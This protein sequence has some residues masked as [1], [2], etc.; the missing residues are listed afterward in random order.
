MGLEGCCFYI[1]HMSEYENLS[2]KCAM[3]W[4]RIFCNP[5]LIVCHF[6]VTLWAKDDIP[7][8]GICKNLFYFTKTPRRG[9]LCVAHSVASKRQTMGMGRK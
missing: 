4:R 3:L 6:M 7:L 8:W 5:I 2:L 9:A 1:L